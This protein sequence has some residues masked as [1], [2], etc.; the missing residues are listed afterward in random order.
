[1][2]VFKP[3]KKYS[4]SNL[5]KTQEQVMYVGI[6]EFTRETLTVNLPEK[7]SRSDQID[8]AFDGIKL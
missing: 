4:L 5:V 1:M 7:L 3:L 2:L 8:Y 6:R